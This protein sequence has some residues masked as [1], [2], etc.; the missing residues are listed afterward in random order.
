MNTFVEHK[1]AFARQYNNGQQINHNLESCG[2]T[3]FTQ[4]LGK[5]V[6]FH[7]DIL[8]QMFTKVQQQEQLNIITEHHFS[9]LFSKLE[10]LKCGEQ[11]DKVDNDNLK[12]ELEAKNEEI[13]VLKAHLKKME[14][15]LEKKKEEGMKLLHWGSIP[16]FSPGCCH[17]AV[18]GATNN[19]LKFYDELLNDLKSYKKGN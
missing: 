8:K 19:E 12:E 7:E 6:D 2:T 13:A 18:Y 11:L 9:A 17:H 1:Q 14:D 5:T 4:K 16:N 10:L 15:A 3:G